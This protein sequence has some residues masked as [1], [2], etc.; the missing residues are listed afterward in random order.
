MAA[1]AQSDLSRKAPEE[2]PEGQA[3][4]AEQRERRGR[5]LTAR[6]KRAELIFGGSF[7]AAAV[8]LIL[9]VPAERALD[10]P[11]AA[12]ILFVFALASQVRFE[13]ASCYTLPTQL[14]FVPALF[15][16]PPQAVPVVVALALVI[17]KAAEVLKWHAPLG[18]ALP[19]VGDAWFC[20]GPALIFSLAGSPGPE[21]GALLLIPAVLAQFATEMTTWYLRERMHG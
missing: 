19:A 7:I 5:G 15:L 20:L 17:G 18:R 3:L 14:V 11:L 13:V 2:T 21:D 9:A 12:L 6:E 4:L 10:W 1:M 16:L 8:A